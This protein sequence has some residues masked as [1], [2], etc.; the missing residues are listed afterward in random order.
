MQEATKDLG[1][2]DESSCPKVAP[3]LESPLYFTQNG[4]GMESL[5]PMDVLYE[6]VLDWSK[7]SKRSHVDGER[8]FIER[9]IGCTSSRRFSEARCF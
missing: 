4:V 3:V 2:D 8:S 5:Q 9:F 6:Y 1:I 7:G